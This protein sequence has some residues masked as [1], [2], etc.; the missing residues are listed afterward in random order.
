MSYTSPVSPTGRSPRTPTYWRPSAAAAHEKGSP[1][2]RFFGEKDRDLPMYKD[3]PHS[4]ARSNRA[5][6]Y[7]QRRPVQVLVLLVVLCL[8]WVSSSPTD[9]R[10]VGGRW[11]GELKSS[12]GTNNAG[13][14]DLRDLVHRADK[15][16]DWELRRE[17]VRE[18]FRLSWDAY[19]RDAWGECA[20]WNDLK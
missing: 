19:E 15:W 3:K 6:P 7:W 4:Y 2:D 17:A 18:A 13:I 16:T 12:S 10:P 9:I 14:K 5:R 8:W 11:Q 1:L 20:V